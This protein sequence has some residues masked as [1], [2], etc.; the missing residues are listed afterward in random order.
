MHCGGFGG[1]VSM[2]MDVNELT[3]PGGHLK[4]SQAQMLKAFGQAWSQ[5]VVVI[6]WDYPLGCAKLVNKI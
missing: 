2:R 1:P 5:P 3:G 6:D 4:H